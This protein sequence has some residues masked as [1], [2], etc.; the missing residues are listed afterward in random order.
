[1]AKLA[2][3][4][5]RWR[6]TV[7]LPYCDVPNML[8]GAVSPLTGARLCVWNQRGIDVYLQSSRLGQLVLRRMRCI[9]SN[10]LYRAT[11]LVERYGVSRSRIQIVPN[12]VVLPAAQ[13][14]GAAFRSAHGIGPERFLCS[15][16]ANFVER[17][18]HLVVLDAFRRLCDAPPP[19]RP[20]LVLAGRKDPYFE[21]LA[22]KIEALRQRGAEVIALDYQKDVSGLVAASQLALFSSTTE[23][24]PNAVLE[25]MALAK[26]VVAV[27][28]ASMLEALGDSAFSKQFLVPQRDPAALAA[29]IRWAIENP[30]ILAEAGRLNAA[31]AREQFSEEALLQRT[32]AAISPYLP[33]ERSALVG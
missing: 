8:C 18:D 10:S 33:A 14:D 4:L 25:A 12:A 24:L 17:K 1:M 9:I 15:M 3:R 16:V 13:P 2:W 28:D 32:I 19:Q 29:R 30:A 5:R 27:E 31:R 11:E 26:P 6:P 21:L 7:L 20:V 23:G 22:P